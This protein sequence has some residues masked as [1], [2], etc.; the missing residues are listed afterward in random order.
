MIGYLRLRHRPDLLATAFVLLVVGVVALVTGRQMHRFVLGSGL[1]AC[2]ADPSADCRSLVSS[3][4]ERFQGLQVLIVPLV[5]LPGLLG[6]YLAAPLVAREVEAGT[7][8]FLW[9][10][11]V[12]RTRWMLGSVVALGLVAA[13]TGLALSALTTAW[14]GDVERVTHERFEPGRFDLVGVAPLGYCLFAVALGVAVG[15]LTG[16]VVTSTVTTLGLFVATRLAVTLLV[17]PRLTP[18]TT[19]TFDLQ[20]DPPSGSWLIDAR[21][22]DR[23]GRVLGDGWSLDISR[24]GC[25]EPRLPARGLPDP[26][27]IQRCL[28]ER[29]IHVVAQYHPPAQFWTVQVAELGLY[30]TLAAVLAIVAV[31]TVRHRIS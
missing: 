4:G 11:G 1:D 14:L 29:G 2:L 27:A 30:L 15:A 28:T 8:R 25:S 31:R 7:H 17:R 26:S 3:F 18:A 12:G 6:S 20:Q 13:L 5:L 22:V 23:A 24:L 10:Q 19:A 21:T 9:T 16:K